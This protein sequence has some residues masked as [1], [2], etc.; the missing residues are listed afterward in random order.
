MATAKQALRK[1]H[2]SRR[3]TIAIFDPATGRQQDTAIMDDYRPGPSYETRLAIGTT[4]YEYWLSYPI[5]QD[6]NGY[7]AYRSNKSGC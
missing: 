7:Y 3:I 5:P 2:N 4:G 1:L 6:E